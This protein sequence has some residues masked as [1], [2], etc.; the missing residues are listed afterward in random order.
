MKRRSAKTAHH[1]ALALAIVIPIFLSLSYFFIG[2]LNIDTTLRTE[3][4]ANALFASQIIHSNPDYWRF[5]QIRLQ[6]FLSRRL[7]KTHNEIRR[8]VDLN[9]ATVAEHRDQVDYPFMIRSHNLYDSGRVVANLEIV[10]SLRPL[11]GK[12]L[13]VGIFAYLL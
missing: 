5:E 2:Y 7:I 3:A 10:R 1:I 6:E 12:T 4:E 9:N 8:I 13:L 11:L